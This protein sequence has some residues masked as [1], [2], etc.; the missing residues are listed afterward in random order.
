MYDLGSSGD[1]EFMILCGVLE[2]SQHLLSQITKM[3]SN[4]P[5]KMHMVPFIDERKHRKIHLQELNGE[6][7]SK[8]MKIGSRVVRGADWKWDDQVFNK[9][10]EE[11]GKKGVPLYITPIKTL[12][13]I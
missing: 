5:D 10:L 9:I 12:H 11:S 6:E 1:I 13:R 7:I 4:K 8:I 3:K 2:K